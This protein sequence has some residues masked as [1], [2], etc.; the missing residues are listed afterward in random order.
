MISRCMITRR[1]LN[2]KYKFKVDESRY[3]KT[4]FLINCA[5]I[6]FSQSIVDYISQYFFSRFKSGVTPHCLYRDLST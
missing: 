1:Y 3:I 2:A 5:S 6:Y 4:F